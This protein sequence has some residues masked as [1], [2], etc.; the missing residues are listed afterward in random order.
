MGNDTVVD[1]A[2]RDKYLLQVTAGPTYDPSTHTDIPVNSSTTTPIDSPLATTY[3]TVRIKNYHG[4]PFDSPPTC[5]YFQ[6]PLHTSDR[7]SI[8]FSFVPK[9]DLNGKDVVHGFDYG[10]SIKHQLPPG[11]K[12]AMKIATS[13]LD[14]GLYSD[15]YCDEPYLYGPAL[16]GLFSINVGDLVSEKAAEEQLSTLEKE[17]GGVVEEGA[18]C[19]S[20]AQIRSDLN[21][22]AKFKK[23]RKFFLTPQNLE[24]FTF[25]K[26]RMYHA[27]FFNPHLDFAEFSLRLPG[28]SIGV[29]RYIDEK[30]HHL[31]YVLKDR[32]TGEV[33][34]VVF[35]KL[36]FGEELERVKKE[37]RGE[38]GQEEKKKES[39]SSV[40]GKQGREIEDVRKDG[41]ITKTKVEQPSA[42]PTPRIEDEEASGYSPTAAVTSLTNNVYAALVAMGLWGDGSPSSDEVAQTLDPSSQPSDPSLDSRVDAMD[43]AT[44]EQYLQSRQSN[45]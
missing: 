11:F 31:R 41:H 2:A 15:A 24:K 20:G 39:L 42:E 44:I 38:S 29:A 17:N 32:S 7:Y 10:H 22:P 33:A 13:M 16:S 35:F 3:L 21:M 34:F 30:T 4:L 12:Y 26:G 27:D 1:P 14:P 5:S 18:S 28:F 23:R 8:A 9:R 40:D 36:L 19:A 43:D 6:H 25:E 45:V 37:K